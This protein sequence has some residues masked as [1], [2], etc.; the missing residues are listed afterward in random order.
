MDSETH[1]LI[2]AISSLS[3]FNSVSPQLWQVMGMAFIGGTILNLLPCVFPVLFLKAL[4]LIRSSQSERKEIRL[5][6]F[7][8][9]IG[10]LVSFWIVTFS[11]L[12]LRAGGHI[13]GWG[14]QFQSPIF[15]SVMIL[16]LFFLGLSLAGAFELGLRLTSV[17]GS[18]AEKQGYIGSFF[19]G[20]LAVVVATPCT[21][22]FMGFAI[23]YALVQP[24][25]I[26]F[27]VFS[28]LGM[29]LAAPYLLLTIQPTWARLLPRPGVWMEI[30]KHAA[31]IP[32]FGFCIWFLWIYAQSEGADEV[33]AILVAFLLLGIAGSILRN[34]SARRS[35]ILCALS[36]IAIA[37]AL[38]IY[39]LLHY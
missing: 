10:I 38:P 11:L 3:T 24:Y 32:M 39:H 15:L 17:G 35:S 2:N 16:L 36:L 29:G 33:K 31:A 14:F 1:Q 6:G 37:F 19:T 27:L 13:I 9:T 28:S 7:A 12:T 5:H 23:G 21:G 18:L 8:Y 30:V 25:W 22:P 4:W 20:V 26:C 34:W